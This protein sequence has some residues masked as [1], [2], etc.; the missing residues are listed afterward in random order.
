MLF[1]N[2][3]NAFRSMK[4]NPMLTALMIAATAVGIGVSMT[5]I[6]LYYL[7]AQN[8]IPHKSEQLYRIQVDSWNPMHPFDGNR[9]ERAPNQVTYRDAMAFID[10]APAQKQS[11][12]FETS[13]IVRPPNPDQLPFESGARVTYGDFFSMFDVPF[14]FGAGW[15]ELMDTQA[16]QVV[17]LTR[18]MNNRL[19]GGENSV[20]REL[21]L[22]N[23]YFTVVGV[24]DTW[25]PMP[26][27]FD[28]V[29]GALDEVNDLMIPMT[30]TPSMELRSAANTSGWKAEDIKTFEDRLNSEY[31]WIQYWAELKDARAKD[32]Y[33]GYLDSYVT[34]QKKLGRFQRPLNNHIHSVTEW[35][36]Y[37]EI[38]P[39]EVKLLVGI[40]LLFLLV[41]LLSTVSLLLTKFTGF[42]T[43]VS[44]RRALGASR[45]AILQQQLVEVVVIGIAG[46]L[47]G[48][49]LTTVSL[50]AMQA[51]VED[52][53]EA[54]FHMN[55]TLIGLAILISSLTS[56]IAGLYPAWRTCLVEPAAE[57]KNL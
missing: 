51:S 41:S 56:L 48:I 43:E 45:P 14:L 40:G 57:L 16:S 11:A 8:P 35:M 4:K 49:G 38:I 19:F 29:G 15:D 44:I 55:W 7:M 1:Y 31:V 37:S 54:L 23:R 20:G 52:A 21:S 3:Q 53:P 22:N 27:Y 34:E 32:E 36:D 18:N 46:G 50:K 25:R 28:L 39:M 24:I 2:I 47:I 12:M 6:T 5:M 13:L 10:S 9:P 26:R 17:V 42:F 33:L 30:L